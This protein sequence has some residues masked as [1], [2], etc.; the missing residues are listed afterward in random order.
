VPKSS[1]SSAGPEAEAGARG[2]T[3]PLVRET[4]AARRAAHRFIAPGVLAVEGPDRE[5]FLQ[6]Q[7]TQDVRGLA[8]G[9]A[10]LAAGLT[11]K[12]KVLF[13]ATLLAEPERLLL[14]LP[15]GAVPAVV[16]H[17]SRYAA[18]QKTT[19]RDA[20]EGRLLA[21]LYGADT[22]SVPLPHG[23]ARLPPWGEL[24][25]AILAPDSARETLEAALA[26][27]GSVPLSEATAEALR[28]EA[29]R[30]RLGFDA[31]DAHLPDEVGLEAA[32]SRTKGCYVG[33]EIVARRKTYGKP[34]RRLV[35]FRFEDGLLEPGTSLAS[36]DRLDRELSRVT[37]AAVSARFGPIGLGVASF[38]AAEGATLVSAA[39]PARRA[40][41][42]GLPFQ[43]SAFE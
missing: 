40:L 14:V 4:E 33:Q 2:E 34:T 8:P 41:V 30:P 12:G 6:G 10:R 22:A 20:S 13:F 24:A 36:P 9:A 32:I 31:T 1:S 37:S 18:F 28:I 42:T 17:L 19:V 3:E 21:E 43:P 15:L 29:G 39:E 11:P 5:A 23:G 35:G 16:A 38:E 25:G 27:V 7:L 26:A